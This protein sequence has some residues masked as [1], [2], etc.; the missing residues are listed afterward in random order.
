MRLKALSPAGQILALS[1]CEQHHKTV[2]DYVELLQSCLLEDKLLAAPKKAKKLMFTD[3]FIYHA[4][5][6]WINQRVIG[7]APEIISKLVEA[8]VVTH[9]RRKYPTYYISAEGQV[10]LAY[11]DQN[12]F[13]PIE[14]KWT[15]QLRPKDLKQIIIKTA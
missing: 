7:N 13:W 2:A 4:L 6:V 5:N 11:V 10:D 9:F 8:T 3:P 15:Q 1:L 14:I 12:Q